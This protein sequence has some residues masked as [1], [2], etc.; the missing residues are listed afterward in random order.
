MRKRNQKDFTPTLAR[1][2]PMLPVPQQTS[3]KSVSWS[4]SAS[5]AILLYSTSAAAVFTCM[6]LVNVTSYGGL[7]RR[8]L[9]Y[10]KKGQGRDGEVQVAHFLN[11]LGGSGQELSE[12]L[13]VRFL[14]LE[15]LKVQRHNSSALDQLS[16]VSL[17]LVHLFRLEVLGVNHN[18]GQNLTL[19]V[20]AEKQLA[21]E[22]RMVFGIE[23]L[24]SGRS[25][26]S[27]EHEDGGLN[28]IWYE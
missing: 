18:D 10:L 20:R 27:L 16:E 23:R 4:N 17:H 11:E 15:R 6:A 13:F 24:A 22:T 7:Y 28:G 8:R 19:K 21:P 5:S 14:A 25:E 2:K 12:R 1:D 26:M 9:K 3:S